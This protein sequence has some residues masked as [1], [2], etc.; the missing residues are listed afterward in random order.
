MSGKTVKIKVD[1]SMM[2]LIAQATGRKRFEVEFSEGK[3]VGDL[4]EYIAN[5]FGDKVKKAIF[6]EQGEF[7][8]ILGVAVNSERFI[9][10][11]KFRETVLGDGD[12]VKIMAFFAG[13]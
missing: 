3:T 4:M 2:P 10:R 6:N 12:E 7:D 1:V 13:G 11:D 5:R 8:S 9:V